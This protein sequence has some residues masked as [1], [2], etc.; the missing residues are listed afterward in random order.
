MGIS[1]EKVLI[2]E[3]FRMN[4]SIR[5]ANGEKFGASTENEMTYL[6]RNSDELQEFTD[7][8]KECEKIVDEELRKESKSKLL[9]EVIDESYLRGDINYQTLLVNLK[10]PKI[11]YLKNDCG[12]FC[13]YQSIDSL[14]LDNAV[15]EANKEEFI[16]GWL[17]NLVLN[18]K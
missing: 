6:V 12:Y 10:T 8:V 17:M 13:L 7:F 5:I 11:F 16:D 4:Y 18:E 15:F 9:F 3:K 2:F 1:L 14:I